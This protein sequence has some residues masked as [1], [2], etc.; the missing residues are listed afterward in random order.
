[1][2]PAYVARVITACREGAVPLYFPTLAHSVH[3][4]GPG[5]H[6]GL[7]DTTYPFLVDLYELEGLAQSAFEEGGGLAQSAWEG[8]EGR[9]AQSACEEGAGSSHSSALALVASLRNAPRHMDVTNVLGMTHIPTAE[10]DFGELLLVT[11]GLAQQSARSLFV[12]AAGESDKSVAVNLSVAEG[13]A[14]ATFDILAAGDPSLK[15]CVNV[16]LSVAEGMAHLHQSCGLLHYDL[17][18]SNVLC[19]RLW[20]GGWHG[21]VADYGIAPAGR[22]SYGKTDDVRAFGRLCWALLAGKDFPTEQPPEQALL[23]LPAS[24]PAKLRELVEECLCSTFLSDLSFVVL[25]ARLAKIKAS[26]P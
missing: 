3:V 14:K 4:G 25:V 24:T 20:D 10:G 7:F 6:G 17:Q 16:C 12:R 9:L 23:Q 5:S 15:D 22:G 13:R 26:M 1:D 8:G 18:P 2:D 11:E 19:A 21:L